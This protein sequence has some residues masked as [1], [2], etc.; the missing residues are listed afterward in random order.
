MTTYTPEQLRQIDAQVAQVMGWEVEERRGWWD[1]EDQCFRA[2]RDNDRG[3]MTALCYRADSAVFWHELPMFTSDIADAWRCI[4][5]MRERG[6][7]Y[8]LYDTEDG[9]KAVFWH[10]G[11]MDFYASRGG[12]TAPLAICLAVLAA[13]GVEVQV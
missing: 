4:D 10:P 9:H 1:A 6:W 7:R 13:N 2:S 11:K 8:W 3:S 12:P 5:Y